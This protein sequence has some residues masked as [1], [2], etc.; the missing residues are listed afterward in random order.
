MQARMMTVIELVVG[1]RRDMPVC[2]FDSLTAIQLFMM[3]D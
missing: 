2:A 1:T 3:A